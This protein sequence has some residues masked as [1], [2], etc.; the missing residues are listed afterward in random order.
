MVCGGFFPYR[1]TFKILLSA[2]HDGLNRA[3]QPQQWE[4]PRRHLIIS[5][6]ERNT[7][8]EAALQES[9]AYNRSIVESSRD[10][11]A[12]LDLLGNLVHLPRRSGEMLHFAA[13]H[14]RLGSS[15]LLLW[16]SADRVAARDAVTMAAAGGTGSFIGLMP[17]TDVE[18]I[19]WDVLITPVRDATGSIHHVL[20]VA[21]DITARRRTEMNAICLAAISKDILVLTKPSEVVQAV[22]A[23][24]GA[25]LGVNRCSLLEVDRRSGGL[26][27][28]L[29]WWQEG[30]HH[31]ALEIP[32]AE[33]FLSASLA[34]KPFATNPATPDGPAM[35]TMS[36]LQSGKWTHSL[37]VIRSTPHDWRSDEIEL[38]S[39]VSSRLSALLE[40][41][42][43]E[44]T[45]ARLAAIVEHSGDAIVSKDLHGI[46]TSWNKG[47]ESLFGYTA[48]EMVGSSIA[49][50][51]PA[52]LENEETSVLETVKRGESFRNHE[53]VRRTK[54]GRLIDISL[55]VSPIIN[56]CGEIIGA[57]KF[58]R[59]ISLRKQ[60]EKKLVESEERFRVMANAIIQLA[61]IAEPD[62][63]IFWYNQSWY[64]YTGTTPEAMQGWGWQSVPHPDELPRVME[65]WGNS[66]AHGQPFEMTFPLRGADGL[67]RQFL[68]RGIP[69][70]DSEGNV[71]RWFGTNTDIDEIT[72]TEK[73]LRESH[74]RITLAHRATGVGIWEWHIATG[75]IHWDAEMF[76]IY[77][78]PPT[79]DGWVPFSTWQNA[80]LSD[81]LLTQETALRDTIAGNG[82]GKRQFRILRHG[83]Q[84]IRHIETVDVVRLNQEG[85]PES[86]VGTNLDITSRKQVE[87]KLL[88]RT[89]QLVLSLIHI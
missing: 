1:H 66:I 32:L 88:E 71:V 27:R 85:E 17:V 15:W 55:T 76:R 89:A 84:E 79:E 49:Q 58:A 20:A 35:L 4:L 2:T 7:E 45:S 73:A 65:N 53:T 31:A 70:K 57:S 43:G 74:Q 81:D 36:L 12:V 68:T 19:W 11:I 44:E 16:S 9:D 28:F 77:G 33:E 5:D 46:V 30:P 80:V 24:L 83:D 34:G 23:R 75:R 3:G 41:V 40:R 54:N 47:A 64:D 26:K 22:G 29:D 37:C 39:E 52:G 50:L 69:L 18:S 59:D 60:A 78:V 13:D 63:N 6:M 86:I 38:V 51:I 62:G 87:K 25:H 8:A 10:C 21:R 67:Y 82:H 42:R 72:R 61:W 56:S 14:V 48:E